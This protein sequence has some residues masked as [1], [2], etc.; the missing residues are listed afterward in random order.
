VKT[1]PAESVVVISVVGIG[2][3]VVETIGAE[4]LPVAAWVVACGAEV[5]VL[6][7]CAE[8]AG[9]AAEDD[10]IEVAAEAAEEVAEAVAME[11]PA[12]VQYA[13]PNASAAA[14]S[15]AEQELATQEL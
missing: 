12:E 13:T 9:A 10:I 14:A 6:E 15:D 11:T 1:S 5:V 3:G 4:E 7:A 8:V 2:E